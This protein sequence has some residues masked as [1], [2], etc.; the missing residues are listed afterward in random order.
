M[1]YTRWVWINV[2]RVFDKCGTDRRG[3]RNCCG[4]V[5]QCRLGVRDLNGSNP[6]FGIPIRSYQRAKCRID[7]GTAALTSVH[8]TALKLVSDG[9]P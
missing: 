2:G 9:L 8:P 4:C 3:A 1:T 6:P 5:E 7:S